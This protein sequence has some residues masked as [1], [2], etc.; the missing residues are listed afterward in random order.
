MTSFTSERD[1]SGR[2][3]AILATDGFEESELFEPLE[4]LDHARADTSVISLPQTPDTIQGEVAGESGEETGVNATVDE[5]SVDDF[6]ALLLPG[7]RRSVDRLRKSDDALAFVRDFLASGKVVAAICHGPWLIAAAG[8]AEGR[9]VTSHPK[10]RMELERAGAEWV[11][12]E[13][14][15]DETLVTSRRPADLDSFVE[16]VLEQISDGV[17][18][19]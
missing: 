17:R 10:I 19:G 4:A 14:V 16:E 3:V 5:V 7:G 12:D 18:A 1:L 15:V 9:T 6:D 8:E 11:D 13:V 2:A